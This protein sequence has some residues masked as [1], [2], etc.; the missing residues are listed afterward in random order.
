MLKH[1]S[2]QIFQILKL[3]CQTSKFL[4]LD[5]PLVLLLAPDAEGNPMFDIRDFS[6]LISAI[7]P[8]KG[9]LIG[10]NGSST[11]LLD[12]AHKLNLLVHPWTFRND[13]L[14]EHINDPL[15]EY[16]IFY[17]LGVDAV[18]TDFP[19]T[20]LKARTVFMGTEGLKQTDNGCDE[21]NN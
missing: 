16:R 18:F 15:Q 20:A 1:H 17:Q 9:L 10:S 19:D 6:D 12:L 2:I 14:P 3:L 8:Y 4:I 13:Q 5:L 11:G 21:K 7:G